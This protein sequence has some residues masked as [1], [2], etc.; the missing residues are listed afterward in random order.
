MTKERWEH[1]SNF[2]LP[3]AGEELD[4]GS[5]LHFARQLGTQVV[6]SGR[7]A[8][9]LVIENGVQHRGWRRLWV[10]SY[11]CEDVMDYLKGLN[12]ALARYPCGPWG[13]D[14]QPYGSP[15]D[16][17]LRVNYFGWGIP[18]LT[19]PFE[20]EILEDHTHNPSAGQQ[21]TADFV[22]ASLRKV[23][24]LP[25]GGLYWSPIGHPVPP[26]PPTMP[27]H[28]AA[29]LARLAAMALK[30]AYLGGFGDEH[31]KQR[32]REIELATEAQLLV[33]E[34]SAITDWT[35]LMLSRM[36]LREGAAIR[37]RNHQALARQ[38][39]E[40]EDVRLL[41]PQRCRE[42]MTA[43][44]ELLSRPVRDAVRAQ[45]IARKVY[46]AVLWP[47]P[48][49]SLETTSAASVYSSRV[50]MLHVDS[51]YSVDDMERVGTEV[52]RAVAEAMM[53]T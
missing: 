22:V 28:N 21:S 31:E 33:G 48:E 37:S 26:A 4:G 25:E 36:S 12:I 52:C 14:C 24:P 15:G 5:V 29:V 40:C 20:G 18:P 7:V 1:G 44:I 39:K 53:T 38:L 42:P 11:F 50:L 17:L 23:L 32:V 8:L 34:S 35:Y 41:G 3:D 49:C 16:V 30:R 10:P 46:P 43:V 27:T 6:G 19:R 9:G 45:L 2:A 51:R 47:V 13:E